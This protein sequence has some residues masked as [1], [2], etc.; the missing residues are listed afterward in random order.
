MTMISP[1]L[2]GASAPLSPST[3]TESEPLRSEAKTSR[4]ALVLEH[5][6]V[7]RSIAQ[8]LLVKLPSSI[9]VDDMC[10]VGVTGLI[11][12]AERFDANRP[13]KFRTYAEVRIKG[14]MLDYLR[15]LSW[16]PRRLHGQARELQ[17]ARQA[18]EAHAGRNATVSELAE[19][20]GLSMEQ[21]H[22]LI[23]E[24]SVMDLQSSD[25]LW[26]N[27]G[28]ERAN[29]PVADPLHNPLS[30]VERKE[31]R[32]IIRQAADALTERQKILLKL[33][34]DEEMTMKEVGAALQITESRASQLHSKALLTM[35]REVL[36]LVNDRRALQ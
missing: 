27:D 3:Y 28:G 33:Y 1:T 14:A 19:A 12:A 24:I 2:V 32:E 18:L 5:L 21:Y 34:Y 35:R 30:E 8:R 6:P 29:Q 4:D 22:L 36:R 17:R 23:A 16:V 10:S 11:D 13:V 15:S 25:E 7:V 20:L 31:M 26:G 9:D